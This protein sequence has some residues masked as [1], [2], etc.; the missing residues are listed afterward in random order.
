MTDAELLCR[1]AI[2]GSPEAFRAVVDRYGRLVYGSALRQVGDPHLAEDVSQAVFIVLS[3]RA[4]GVRGEHL[5]GWLVNT[6]RLTARAA[7]RARRRRAHHER[8]AAVMWGIF[9]RHRRHA[10]GGHGEMSDVID[11]ALARLSAGDRSAVALHFLAGLT[12][13][14]VAAATGGTEES[15]RKRV[16]RALPRLRE[17]LVGRGVT[18]A[19]GAG[20]VSDTLYRL[21]APALPPG[22]GEAVCGAAAAAAGGSAA[23]GVTTLLARQVM[24]HMF[25]VKAQIVGAAV[26]ALVAVGA[27][28]AA[29]VERADVVAAQSTAA[30]TGAASR[31]ASAGPTSVPTELEVVCVDAAGKPV[32]GAEVRFHQA[33]YSDT[34]DSR[35]Q[36]LPAATT[37]AAGRVRLGKLDLAAAGESWQREVLVRVPGQFLGGALRGYSARRPRASTDGDGPLRIVLERTGTVAGRVVVPAGF[38]PEDVT[39]RAIVAMIKSGDGPFG[40]S[41]DPERWKEL[42][43]LFHTRVN[44]DGTFT[45]ADVPTVGFLHLAAEG[46]GLGQRQI[47]F[48][49]GG[50]TE[51]LTFNLRREA[52]IEGT[53]RRSDDTPAP[54]GT[55]VEV[56]PKMQ[57]LG[58]TRAFRATTDDRGHFRVAGLAEGVFAVALG[59]VPGVAPRDWVMTT[60]DDLRVLS[61]QTLALD[62]LRLV[63]GAL[64]RG[65]VVDDHGDAVEG[66]SIAALS[67]SAASGFS[68]GVAGSDAKGE[69][70]LRL[71]LGDCRL[72]FMD[73]PGGTPRGRDDA[74]IVV[75]VAPTDET[76]SVK[77]QLIR[78]GEERRPLPTGA[79]RGRVIDVDG[80]P[81][82]DV[83]VTVF[84]NEEPEDGFRR[85]WSR[86]TVRTGSDGRFEIAALAGLTSHVRV[87]NADYAPAPAELGGRDVTAR[88]PKDGAVGVGDV[89]VQ[90]D[91][92]VSEVT[93]IVTDPDGH[94]LSDAYLDRRFS[95]AHLQTDAAGRFRL[96]VRKSE[97]SS[98]VVVGMTRD[99]YTDRTWVGIPPGT[100]DAR[101][102][103]YPY[104]AQKVGPGFDKS[105]APVRLLN[106]PAPA[107]EVETWVHLPASGAPTLPRKDGAWTLVVF[108]NACG[109]KGDLLETV[110]RLEAACAT[111]P[112]NCVGLLICDTVYHEAGIRAALDGHRASVAV[113]VDRFGSGLAPGTGGRT[114]GTWGLVRMPQVF[115]VDPGGLVRQTQTG[116]EGVDAYIK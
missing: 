36:V 62:D 102:I 32:A 71:P 58:S 8:R 4:G 96:P 79:V 46:P 5:A 116:L 34:G 105:P 38:R 43:G 7:V 31:L 89:I 22:F 54:A 25:F 13:Q 12:F 45:L 37:D 41:A 90:A 64:V 53:L 86:P 61:G 26:L 111:A 87:D 56:H 40:Y 44:A 107:L 85:G 95:S 72:Y 15:V 20:A 91:P 75:R 33:C 50:G 108:V 49:R 109:P 104:V 16:A 112:V 60:R 66:A 80:K 103:L 17:F 57:T 77:M 101:F 82:A 23:A 65:R 6:T 99:A 74:G 113:G 68:V 28:G 27:V 48:A 83:P 67:P 81:L 19:A 55:A 84:C 3:R 115:V 100:K 35:E 76:L 10:A 39:V 29:V 47:P 93:G 110:K 52:V 94:P 2:D 18:L 97:A 63:R 78:G 88:P 30:S 114:F 73:V 21:P 92:V 9:D 70:S 106:Q 24:N 42:P 51:A 11:G 1:Y 98:S 14:E 59:P 69:F